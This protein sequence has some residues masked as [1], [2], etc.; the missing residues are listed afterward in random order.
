MGFA[1]LRIASTIQIPLEM[2][3]K[4]WQA[5]F[6]DTKR[7]TRLGL[8]ISMQVRGL[9]LAAFFGKLMLPAAAIL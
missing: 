8:C 1:G 7:L 6:S 3:K 4:S 2:A 5:S 9:W